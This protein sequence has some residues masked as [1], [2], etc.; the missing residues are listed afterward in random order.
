MAFIDTIAKYTQYFVP[1]NT[2]TYFVPCNTYPPF[3][4]I[5]QVGVKVGIFLASLI[6]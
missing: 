1:C 5:S 3:I 4:E 2:L 6:V